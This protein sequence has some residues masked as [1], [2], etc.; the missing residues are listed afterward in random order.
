MIVDIIVFDGVDELDA[1]GPLE[2]LRSA[3]RLGADVEVR[4]VT[5]LPQDLV[6]GRHGLQ[7]RP[8]TTFVAGAADIVIATGGGWGVR[9]ETGAWGEVQRGD[10]LPLLARAAGHTRI[11]ASVCTG[12]MLLAHAG[13]IGTRRATTHRSALDDLR[14]TGATVVPERVVD[15]GDLV[16]AGGVTSGIDLALWLVQRELSPEVA[17]RVARNLEHELL[18]APAQPTG[19]PAAP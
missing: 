18:P 8:D 17:A 13:V 10:W 6:T 15:D 2:V 7:F 3:G 16:T 19:D 4:L 5:R 14:A 12:A 11:M 9:D 1:L